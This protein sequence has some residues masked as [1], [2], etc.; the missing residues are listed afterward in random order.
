MTANPEHD[1][2]VGH[3]PGPWFVH[4]FREASSEPT[5]SDITVSCD[6]PATI[7]VCVMDRALTATVDEALAN[8]HLI[9]A[10]PAMLATITTLVAENAR[11]LDALKCAPI[12]GRGEE[13]MAFRDR[14]NKWLAGKYAA[15]LNHKGPNDDQG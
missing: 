14:Q 10:A 9:A 13:M 3:T 5:V 12:P 7:T 15:A 2:L 11:L 8:A 1:A 6:H 4:D